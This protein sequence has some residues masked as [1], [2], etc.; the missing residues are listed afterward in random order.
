MK[1]GQSIIGVFLFLII[2][3]ILVVG[4]L[5]VL[6]QTNSSNDKEKTEMKKE[7]IHIVAIGD[8][9]T[10][11]VGDTTNSGGYVPLVANLLEETDNYKK[12]TT[13]NYGK[14]GD[15]S[16]Q[17]LARFN[18]NKAMQE[19]VEGADIVVLTVGGNDIIQ[20]FKQNFLTIA[21][22]SFIAPRETYEENL[23]MLFTA[24]KEVNPES[25]LY[26]FGIY[27]PYSAYFPEITEMQT[28]LKEWNNQTQEVV[29]ETEN[30]TFVSIADLFDQTLIQ[31]EKEEPLIDGTDQKK[32]EV[33]NPYLYE[34][35]LFHPNEAGY[36]LMAEI[37]FQAIIK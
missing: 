9:L 26:I 19:D 35:D 27:N 24:I 21:E 29:N 25:E 7:S 31:E 3:I 30:A 6:F 13:S 12:I 32:S 18:E 23:R 34:E 28:I 37:L 22:D 4:L 10:E 17:I 33:K 11:G 2:G 1:K 8:S 16:D 36:E 14:S 5:T 15:R 20:T